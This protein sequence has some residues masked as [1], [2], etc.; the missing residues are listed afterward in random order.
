MGNL[1]NW[2]EYD[3]FER[4]ADFH[5]WEIRQKL[6]LPPATYRNPWEPNGRQV[7]HEFLEAY[8]E[9]LNDRFKSFPEGLGIL[10]HTLNVF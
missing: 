8:G 1:W 5:E 9:H 3:Y 2:I 6:H 7:F 10:V 4:Y